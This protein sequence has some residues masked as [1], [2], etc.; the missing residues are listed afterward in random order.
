MLRIYLIALILFN[1]L[2]AQ[3]NVNLQLSWKNQFQFAGYYMAKEKGF[4]ND[5]DLNVNIKEYSSGI[6]ASND[7]VKGKADFGI[8]RSSL[9]C[10]RYKGKPIVMLAAIFQHSPEML[11]VKKRDDITKIEDL[12]N[13]KI[14]LSGDLT[15]SAPINA[16]LQSR[17]VTQNMFTS[18]EH[19]FD[20]QDL[21]DGK[22]DAM[23]SYVS[24]EP[25]AL[26]KQNIPYTIF[27]PS[28]YNFDFYSDILFTS[29]DLIEKNPKMVKAFREASLKG[30]KYAI[31]H[32]EETVA[33]ILKKYNTQHKTNDALLY[34]AN[35]IEKLINKNVI[36]L[37]N[38]DPK[39][40][41][42]IAQIYSLMGFINTHE[43]ITDFI[44]KVQNPIKTNALNLTAEEKSWLE[45]HPVL[46]VS[47]EP[48]YAPWDFNVKGEAKGYSI[49][50]MNL[51]ASKIG[52][53]VEYI[54]DTWNNLVNKLQDKEIDIVHTMFKNNTKK[55]IIYSTPYKKV[56]NAL[57]IHKN[58]NKIKS[59]ADLS[60]ELVSITK[61][62][63]SVIAIQKKYPNT[64]FVFTINYADSLKEVAFNK[65]DAA[66]LEPSVAN[67][68]IKEF[69]IPD[70][71]IVDEFDSKNLG[72]DYAFHFGVHKD[73][74]L[75]VS[76]L[77]KTIQ[78]LKNGEIDALY[79]K[80][81]K[82]HNK[83]ETLKL[84]KAEK[85]FINTH[86]TI[87]LGADQNWKPFD[88]KDKS[89]N[90]AGFDAD[91]TRL[92]EEKLNINIEVKLG[93]WNNILE[94]VKDKKINGI[95]GASKNDKRDKYMVFTKPY[96]MFAQV[97]LVEKD[98]KNISSIS[99]LDG[100]TIALKEGTSTDVTYFNEKYPN[101]K[102]KLYNTDAEILI[103]L[104]EKEVDAALSNIGAASYEIERNFIS[105]VKVAF[106]IDELAG[107]MRYGIR[108]DQPELASI[109][110]KGID[111]ITKDE[112]DIIL[113]RWIKLAV[114]ND[115]LPKLNL[116]KE[117]IDWLN[118]KIPIKY[119]YDPD[120]A[121]FEWENEIGEHTGIVY[122]LLNLIKEKSGI[123]L[124]QVPTQNWSEAVSLMKEDKADMYSAI[125]ENEDKK[126]YLNFT[127]NTIFKT[128][129]VFVSRVDDKS[130]Y[131]ETFQAIKNKKVAVVDGYTIHGI[132]KDKKPN[133][134]ILTVKNLSEG[135]EKVR[136]K[137]LDIFIVN[138]ATARYFIN[139]KGYDDLKIA[140]KIEFN[141][142]LKIALQK[143]LPNE[144]ISIL[145]KAIDSISE[146]ESSDIYYKWTEVKVI[147]KI[148]WDLMMK[149]FALFVL[150]LAGTIYWGRKLAVAKKIAEKAT[151]E[152]DKAKEEV[153]LILTNIL[154]PV[155][156]TSKKDRKI[157]YANKYAQKQYDMPI[158]V[159]IG[160][161]ID[162]LYTVTGQQE[163]I[164]EGIK[165]YG[166]VENLEEVFK[167]S[168]GKE[169]TALLSVTPITYKNE[170]S[171]IGMITDITKQKEMEN[172]VRAI[173]KH[174]KESIEYAALIQSAII[175]DNSIFE[176]FFQDYF[177]IWN[178]KDVVGGDI[179]LMNKINEDELILMIID[180]TGHG[181]PGAFVT[182][183]VKAIER[184]IMANIYKDE[185]ISPSKIL[186][187]FNRSIK[188]LLKQESIDSVS[189]A[190]F[191]GG[192]IYYNKKEK[193]LKFSGA[194]T[195]LF[196]IDEKN[197]FQSI[198]GSRHSVGY[199]KS[200][201]NFEFKEHIIE[202]QDG[203]QFYITTDGY[204]DQNGG[205][206]GFPFGKKQFTR[207]IEENKSNTMENQKGIL[208]EELISYQRE[209]ERNDDVT[210]VGFKV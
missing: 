123:K 142:E 49:D 9:I 24:N 75:L 22:T 65:V 14:M 140:T 132:L 61:G 190:G 112:I 100:K 66:V 70:I 94:E 129:Y 98:N 58:N 52:I 73:N 51:L 131:L 32:K 57:Y 84:T 1:F 50:Y 80:W 72:V 116:T 138:A 167:T 7:V 81:F 120:G 126:A 97:V 185:T 196:Y 89:G 188:N 144:V 15:A 34:E 153:E 31:D 64:R 193:I 151:L 16:M 69:N 105:N 21:I 174:T 134:S 95:I 79:N 210:V 68:L 115:N 41:E 133:I 208:L 119:V 149:V 187:I 90:H 3:E 158:D 20:I 103:A 141:L 55:D 106:N 181:V 11:L 176:H 148:D 108:N 91:F 37:G 45:K 179:Y 165:K 182:M 67:Y 145:D 156:I 53:K 17:K 200:D 206:K 63:S 172:E 173:H 186:S 28:D 152:A 164:I 4:Y 183:L 26:K 118:K 19:S 162:D 184:Q 27:S 124:Q 88:W 86:P 104:S 29:K 101:I 121:P 117:E 76:I 111:L 87:T 38:I 99:D 13:K 102:Q 146:K 201:S 125:G 191:D 62:D 195:A 177:V 107:D 127:K 159:I 44:Y 157:L 207:I 40:I 8:G 46:K 114:A 194:E 93:D 33:L 30:W 48:D 189:N 139:T 197:E 96:F 203:M 155:L 180:C 39:R 154:L 150:F 192:I 128:P 56:T 82:D 12:K 163:H 36:E 161:N 178:P 130:D 71:K 110:Q 166:F 204:L 202:A 168:K 54:N 169:F 77:N 199:K 113:A 60:D 170:E 109:L 10:D 47:S 43:E 59:I 122:D 136:D 137:T 143:E 18:Q 92:L 78:S 135:F 198:K 6:D 147:N 25:Y 205:K 160:S 85:E 2:N 74:Q 5:V 209:E 23:L 42:Y 175:P 83:I 35:E 171:Y